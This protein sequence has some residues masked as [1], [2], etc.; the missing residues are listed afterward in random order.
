VFDASRNI[1]GVDRNTVRAAPWDNVGV[2]YGLGAL[3]SGAITVKQFL[4]LNEGIGGYDTTPIT[5]RPHHRRP[6]AI[7]RA[8]RLGMTLLRRRRASTI[9]VLDAATTTTPAAITT[10]GIT[11]PSASAAAATGTATTTSCGAVCAKRSQWAAMVRWVE[12]VKADHSKRLANRES[13]PQQPADVVDGCWTPRRRA[14]VHRRADH[15]Q[16][17][18]LK[19]NTLYPSY[20]FPRQRGRRPARRQ[21]SSLR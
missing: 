13:A 14:N 11:S 9:P 10:R 8:T 15:F 5:S 2:Q 4:D 1:Y 19:C 7:K 17:P 18:D 6:R 20:A 16:Q 21:P 3:N 12:A